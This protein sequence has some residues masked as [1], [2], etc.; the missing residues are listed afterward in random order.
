MGRTRRGRVLSGLRWAFLALA[1]LLVALVLVDVAADR[2]LRP[3]IERA[4][5]ERLDG[6]SV[7]LRAVDFSP[8][9]LSLELRDLAVVQDAH[10]EPPV[11]RLPESTFSVHWRSLLLGRLVADVLLE[12]PRLAIDLEQLR[13]ERADEV[14]L[15]ERGWQE[16]LLAVYPLKINALEM[17][18]G[19]LV[20][21]HEGSSHPLEISGVEATATNIRNVRS[22]ELSYPSEI[23]GTARVFD[24]GRLALE[25]QADFLAQPH[26]GVR[27][28][29]RLEAVPLDR[30]DPLSRDI[31]LVVSGGELSAEG[32]LEYAGHRRALHLEDLLLAGVHVDYLFD[33]EFTERALETAKRV[34]REPWID[35]S[36][37]Q[38]RVADGE[39]A[40]VDDRREPGYRVFLS[41][42]E[43]RL[44][45]LES[46]SDEP[47]DLRV[48]G[49]FMGS[50][51]TAVNGSFRPDQ[52]G[53]DFDIGVAIRGTE[54]EAMNDLLASY[55]N[56]D[57]RDGTFSFYC[58]IGVRDG[59]LDGYI[60]PLF[61][62]VDVYDPE[63]DRHK[64]FFRRIWE[65]IADGL[66]EL[67]EN[68]PRDEVATI[69]DL[70][71]SAENPD[72]S[73]GQ[74]LVNLIR[75]AFIEAILPGFE[76]Q[77]EQ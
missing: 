74:V 35:Y 43:V 34:E 31:R 50:G 12:A 14:E 46:R 75:N 69:A 36:I 22:P 60:K 66:A 38:L 54:L 16:A 44:T 41:D 3:R 67:L 52:D 18:D 15:D 20:Y 73:N 76:R 71:G 21:T 8:W 65:R 51:E 1:L 11:A 64:G 29:F 77:R 26:A 68:R 39:L 47:S 33:P 25:G 61:E 63:Q 37:E 55:V 45:G 57:V 32:E 58:E 42:A 5:N 48:E 62:E 28:D 56:L 10:P 30:L 24:A 70:Q 19:A 53:A 59:A 72:A 2:L 4:M 23:R 13:E 40:L 7:A 6:Y 49:L 27:T 9:S 17:R